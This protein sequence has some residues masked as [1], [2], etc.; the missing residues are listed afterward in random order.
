[1][2]SSENLNQPLIVS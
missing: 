1:M 2:K